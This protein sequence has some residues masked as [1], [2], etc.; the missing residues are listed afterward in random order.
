MLGLELRADED[1]LRAPI[2][3]FAVERG[4]DQGALLGL[5]RPVFAR[6]VA[7]P[8]SGR[9]VAYDAPACALLHCGAR[10]GSVAATARSGRTRGTLGAMLD[11]AALKTLVARLE[12]LP[13]LRLALLF[14]SSACGTNRTD[15]DV[16]IALLGDTPLS[17]DARLALAADLDRALGR[18]IDLVDLHGVPEPL[19]GEALT[20][21]TLIDRNGARAELMSRHLVAVEDF[22]PLQRRLLAERRRRFLRS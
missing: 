20:G 10:L 17:G 2:P 9:A 7:P 16:D 19:T 3:V 18:E 12:P 1:D 14:G 4:L 11:D 6:H 21:R 22:V 13:G 15:S 8:E 5:V